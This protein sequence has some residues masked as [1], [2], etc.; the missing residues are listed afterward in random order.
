MFDFNTAS[1]KELKDSFANWRQTT[2]R[3]DI[4]FTSRDGKKINAILTFPKTS[5]NSKRLPVVMFPHGGPFA[6][7]DLDFDFRAHFLAQ[8]GYLVVQPNY[9]G[10]AFFGKD[11]RFAGFGVVGIKKAQQD[12]EDCLKHLINIEIAD[13]NKVAILGGSWGGYCAAYA[14]TFTPQYYK[15]GV[16]LFGAYNLPE[17]LKT[18]PKKSNANRGLDRIQYGILPKDE[19]ALKT[20]SPYFFAHKISSPVMM[21]HFKDDEIIEYA[22]GEA[23]AK[24][25]KELGKDVRFISGKGEHGFTSD[26]EEENQYRRIVDFFNT[27][28]KVNYAK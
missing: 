16:L 6:K 23:Y 22:Q 17:M 24:K 19:F 14:L 2:S 3:K 9:R 15:A 5:E 13:K 11:F 25:L 7:A 21:Y 8:A 18:F 10:S 26:L 28:L 27:K 4:N 12:I 20:I 1:I